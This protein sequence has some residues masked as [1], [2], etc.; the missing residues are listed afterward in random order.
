M[1]KILFLTFLSFPVFAVQNAWI[2]KW[3]DTP[4]PAIYERTP[5]AMRTYVDLPKYGGS[6]EWT[7][8]STAPTNAGNTH[9]SAASTAS[10]P[11]IATNVKIPL[12]ASA[13]VAASAVLTA[14]VPKAALVK[15]SMALLRGATAA[16]P[17]I[18][19][20]LTVGWL[21]NAGYKYFNDT[22]SFTAS[23]P[24]ITGSLTCS[25]IGGVGKTAYSSNLLT[26]Y[27]IRQTSYSDLSLCPAEQ[28]DGLTSCPEY[29]VPNQPWPVICIHYS[30]TPYNPA[31]TPTTLDIVQATLP[32]TPVSGS[33]DTAASLDGVVNE[34]LKGGYNPDTDGLT[35]SLIGSS[36]PVQGAKTS[37]VNPDNSVSTKNT[38]YN[39][40]YTNNYVDTTQT[41]TTVNTPASGSPVTTTVT[42]A[43]D[44]P[45]LTVSGTIPANKTDC[46]LFP[47][48]VGC[49]EFGTVPTPDTLTTINVPA[50]LN[51]GTFDSGICPAPQ[52]LN[53]SFTT[54]EM[55][56]APLCSLASM[57][58]PLFIALAFLSAGL[59]VL[60]PIRS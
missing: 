40:T 11:K 21:A 27:Y 55:S 31:V 32:T 9:Y 2:P 57:T 49:A 6:V 46:E 14:V 37:I 48:S 59:L 1:I 25:K 19:T 30:T 41:T 52:I 56:F 5:T 7:L 33:S 43:A 58:K 54:L 44:S 10:T 28:N 53:L 34:A 23:E 13:G 22:D 51:I 42:S 50:S 45:T 24:V 17:Y 39:N 47:A 20:A 38:V 4:A 18:A 29:A 35:P 3:L 16:N 15:A 8:N 12:G 60:A 26:K 36:T